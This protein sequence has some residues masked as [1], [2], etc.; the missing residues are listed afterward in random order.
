MSTTPSRTALPCWNMP[1]ASGPPRNWIANTPLPAALA[2]STNSM[3]L[4]E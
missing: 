3:K 4:F 1:I 2:F